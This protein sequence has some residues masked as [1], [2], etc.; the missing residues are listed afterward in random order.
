[1]CTLC[2]LPALSLLS[3]MPRPPNRRSGEEFLEAAFFF[4]SAVTRL[5]GTALI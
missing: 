3:Q 5:M 4:A 1:M 2:L